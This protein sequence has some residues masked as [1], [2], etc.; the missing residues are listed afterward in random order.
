[1][2][3]LF[4]IFLISLITLILIVVTKTISFSETIFPVPDKTDIKVETQGAAQRLSNIIRFQTISYQDPS[5]SSDQAFS[6]MQAYLQ[7]QF[8]LVFQQLQ[9]EII[10]GKSMLFRWQGSDPKLNPV[11]LLAHQDV[12][13]V[14]DDTLSKWKY[15]PFSGYVDN[16]FIWGR[17]S[18]DDKSSLMS[19]FEAVNQ[20]L[21]Q[22]FAPKR[23]LYLAFGHDEEIGG[24]QGAKKI[25]QTLASRGVE[26]DYVLDEGGMISNGIM[27]GIDKK[28]AFIGTVE[29]GFLSLKLKVNAPGGHS[30]MPPKHTAIGILGKAILDL[31]NNPLPPRS[32]FTIKFIK[33]LT[34]HMGLLKKMVFANN[35][36]FRP[37]IENLLSKSSDTNAMIRTTV[38]ATMIKGGIKDNV[39]PNSAEAIINLRIIPGDTVSSVIKA[40]KA[41]INNPNVEVSQVRP[42]LNPSAISSQDGS[43]FN[44]IR[45]TILEVNQSKD[46]M[47]V[48]PY[49]V[50]G[51]T[52][53]RHFNQISQNTYRFLYMELEKEDI[54]RFHGIN[55]RISKDNF[56]NLIRFY[57]QLIKNSQQ[58]HLD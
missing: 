30:S 20:L 37:I 11:L 15:P 39:L 24:S 4:K 49:L 25:A 5:K 52:D 40:V 8:P 41:I 31:D 2:K 16:E 50:I 18:M 22:Q 35:W 53:S 29:K 56:F 6:Q 48:S 46:D 42:G 51:G 36:F 23:T 45:S 17:G 38:A 26:L 55:E 43:T 13:P 57:Y 58:E 44:M 19:I 12:V 1:M 14:P 7:S 28:V 21:Q 34:H 32:K 9:F 27:P 47:L 3:S 33:H 10:N 54:H